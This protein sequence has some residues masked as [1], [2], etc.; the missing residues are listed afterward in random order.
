MATAQRT[1]TITDPVGIHARPASSFTQA[2]GESGC[3]VTIAKKPGEPV[4]AASI[5]S[6]MA[7]GIKQ[8]DT[9]EITVNGDE[10][11]Q[12][13]DKLIEILTQAE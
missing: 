4:N 11:E 5:L 1:T 9:V 12:Q 7:L 10:A 3:T 8:G 6:I 2:V 13:A